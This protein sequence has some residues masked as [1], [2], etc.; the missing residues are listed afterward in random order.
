MQPAKESAGADTPFPLIKETRPLPLR[1]AE[2]ISTDYTDQERVK[3]YE[4]KTLHK[5]KRVALHAQRRGDGGLLRNLQSRRLQSEPQQRI[6]IQADRKAH[7]DSERRIPRMAEGTA[8][9]EQRMSTKQIKETVAP[10]RIDQIQPF[11]DHP[12]KV[13]Q[14]AAMAELKESVTLNGVICFSF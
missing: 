7:P 3:T 11:A 12:F 5:Y 14:D 13:E 9:G 4:Q 6:P 1:D 10:I 8:G 2:V